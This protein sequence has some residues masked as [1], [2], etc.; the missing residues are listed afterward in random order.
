MIRLS[1]VLVLLITFFL[2]SN[3]QNYA[4]G[5]TTITFTDAS[6]NNR[7][8]LT[9]IYYPAASN[10]ENVPVTGNQTYPVVVFGHGFVMVWSAYQNI[11]QA[12]VPNGYIAVFPRSEGSILP[13]HTEFAKDLA[14]LVTAIQT[15]NTQSG[16]IFFGKVS[17]KSAVMGHSMG[18]GSTLLSA[19][20][21]ANITAFAALAPAETNPSAVAVCGNITRPTLLIAGTLDCVV[22]TA[23]NAQLMY[24][25]LGTNCKTLVNLTGANHCQFAMSNF[26]C[27]LGESC[28]ATIV[29]DT[30]HARVNRI[31][32]PWLNY[33]LK[34]TCSQWNTYMAALNSAYNQLT[35]SQLC[36]ST[37]I[38]G[39]PTGLNTIN[40]N[41]TSAT[42]QW[43]VVNCGLK[44][45]IRYR[46]VG[47]TRW[48][49]KSTA[50]NSK[51]LINLLPATNYEWQVNTLCQL[52]GAATS[53]WSG[54]SNFTTTN[55]L[56]LNETIEYTQAA[57]KIFPNPS[58]GDCFL[59]FSQEVPAESNIQIYNQLGGLVK[60]IDLNETKLSGDILAIPM[61]QLTPGYY[62]ITLVTPEGIRFQQ[63]LV[64]ESNH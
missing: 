34:N 60:S 57:F 59:E 6:R 8:I 15:Q 19:Q 21:N 39:I 20:Y 64:R 52:T 42:A 36:P 48:T 45:K 24:N 33:H 29:R 23:S 1:L 47:T 14:Y 7:S 51:V 13:S 50:V 56:F 10:G 9:E 44:Y 16:S 5:H 30:Q 4:V 53:G 55:Q 35:Y 37:E 61:D 12:L 11:W 62:I 32:I 46:K 43:N 17:N 63:K 27:S 18:G 49:T 40:I 26:N 25:A 31:L 58:Q 2:Q 38:C 22:P 41:S 3:A 28:S 54:S